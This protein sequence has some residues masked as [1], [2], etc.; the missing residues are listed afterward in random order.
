MLHYL[1]CVTLDVS[2]RAKDS[3]EITVNAN[4]LIDGSNE[5]LTS[6]TQFIMTPCDTDNLFEVMNKVLDEEMQKFDKDDIQIITPVKT[7]AYNWGSIVLN[8]T[9][10]DKFNPVTKNTKI[11][12]YN[13]DG[14]D[15]TLRTGDR[16][17]HLRNNSIIRHYR[18]NAEKYDIL[19]TS[20]LVNGDFGIVR[21][22]IRDSR[23]INFNN[24]LASDN[25]N[26]YYLIVEYKSDDI[27]Y[28]IYPLREIHT[29]TSDIWVEAQDLYDITLGYAVTVHKMEGSEAKS[30]ICPLFDLSVRNFLSNNM[31]YTAI[32]RASESCRLVGQV[33]EQ[34]CLIDKMRGVN[35]LDARYSVFDNY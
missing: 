34:A 17:M 32:T 27:F 5:A 35:V 33:S 3:S 28:V 30:V 26:T 8:N 20:G 6:G 9:F 10:R 13:M 14:V 23:L 2:K 12:H 18:K 15:M 22:I 29:G 21:D 1:P 25:Y 19:E 31:L 4:R 11:I 16:I 24:I 7:K